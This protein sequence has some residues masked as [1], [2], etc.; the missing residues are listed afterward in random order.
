[1][2]SGRGSGLGDVFG[3]GVSFLQP[4]YGHTL[5]EKRRQAIEREQIESGAPPVEVDL[6]AGVIRLL[7]PRPAPDLLRRD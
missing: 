1:M 7:S 4:G 6:V 3:A 2:F 5:E